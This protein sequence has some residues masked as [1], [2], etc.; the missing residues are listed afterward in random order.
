[1]R[2]HI[3]HETTHRYEPAR[4]TLAQLVRLTPSDGPAQRVIAWRVAAELAREPLEFSDGYGNVCHLFALRDVRPEM[5]IVAEGEVETFAAREASG[6][7]LVPPGYFLRATPLTAPT[8]A[9]SALA[10]EAR[11]SAGGDDSAEL[12]AL[13]ELVCERI[14]HHPA[15]TDVT[16]RA[17]DALAG[18]AGVCQDRAHVFVTAA[19][20]LGRPAR[21]VSGYCDGA[22]AGE[23]GAMHAWAE[24]WREKE[25][26]LA[27]DPSLGDVAAQRHVR[28]CVGLDYAE[29][30]PIRGVRSGGARE[31]L[32]VRVR[33]QAGQVQQ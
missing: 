31:Q 5:R 14:M 10:H 22:A 19:R 9:I 3:R 8:P 30:A 23:D 13:A 16:T 33:I 25:G 4:G 1:M 12:L 24:V 18:G 21:Y 26:W 6:I 2:L 29:A 27:L 17:G 15:Q 28:I 32:D 11:A 7:E 20:A